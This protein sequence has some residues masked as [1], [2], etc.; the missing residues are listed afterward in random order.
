M[1]IHHRAGFSIM[2]FFGQKT[3]NFDQKCCK[4]SKS[5]PFKVTGGG[6][7]LKNG[8]IFKLCIF[9]NYWHSQTH[10]FLQN[11]KILI[12]C[13]CKAIFARSGMSQNWTF[14]I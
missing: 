5:K 14:P 1:E 9:R 7:W 12:I 6:G 3:A 11:Q 8:L 4:L 13:D 10:S 2:D